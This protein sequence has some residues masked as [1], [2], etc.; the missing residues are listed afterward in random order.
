[1]ASMQRQN[2]FVFIQVHHFKPL[3]TTDDILYIPMQMYVILSF[4][5]CNVSSTCQLDP[6]ELIKIKFIFRE[7]RTYLNYPYWLCRNWTENGL[8]PTTL[9]TKTLMESRDRSLQLAECCGGERCGDRSCKRCCPDWCKLGSGRTDAGV[10]R[11]PFSASRR[12]CFQPTKSEQCKVV[13]Q[14]SC[15]DLAIC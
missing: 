1:M 11:S 2:S 3:R 13:W 10:D 5:S 4:F 7:W 14:A 15:A 9:Q 8:L 12:Y 6:D